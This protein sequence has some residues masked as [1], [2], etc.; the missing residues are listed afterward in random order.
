[1]DDRLFSAS[2]LAGITCFPSLPPHINGRFHDDD[3]SQELNMMRSR[4]WP[5]LDREKGRVRSLGTVQ[6]ISEN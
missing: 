3:P 4:W 1:M 5:V 2:L 6:K